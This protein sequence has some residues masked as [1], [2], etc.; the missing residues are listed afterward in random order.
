MIKVSVPGFE[1]VQLLEQ[2]SDFV[3]RFLIVAFADDEVES[4][5]N[6][7]VDVVGILLQDAVR[8][9]AYLLPILEEEEGEKERRGRGGARVI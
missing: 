5:I 6:G 3:C 8:R 7:A 2:I 4:L 1:S 9:L